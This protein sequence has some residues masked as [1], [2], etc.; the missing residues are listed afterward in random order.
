MKLKYLIFILIA[1]V[2]SV[3]IIGGV[4]LN[5]TLALKRQL[6]QQELLNQ[7]NSLYKQY[8]RQKR[9]EQESVDDTLK[10]EQKIDDLQQSIIDQQ[11]NMEQE[12]QNQ[13]NCESNGGRY[14]GGGTC[15]Y[16]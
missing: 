9:E 2:I 3:G 11:Q 6:Q 10:I 16:Y 12:F 7:Q 1:L 4:Y 14:V 15:V 8:L 5:H 13:Q